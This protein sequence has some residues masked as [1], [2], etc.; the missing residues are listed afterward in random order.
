MFYVVEPR[1]QNILW[2]TDTGLTQG[3]QDSHRQR[4]GESHDGVE[5]RTALQKQRSAC[6]ASLDSPLRHRRLQ[7]LARRQSRCF[8]GIKITAQPLVNCG[9]I[10]PGVV[11][12]AA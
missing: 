8:Q 6:R 11:T 1:H 7:L 12:H 10:G 5:L 4:V 3:M 9:G 2:D